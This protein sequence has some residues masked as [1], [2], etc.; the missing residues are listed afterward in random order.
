VNPPDHSP[1]TGPTPAESQ[2]E[3]FVPAPRP[4]DQDDFDEAAKVGYR[5][6]REMLEKRRK[7]R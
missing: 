3:V 6:I 2:A 7:T 1:D 4:E 5:G